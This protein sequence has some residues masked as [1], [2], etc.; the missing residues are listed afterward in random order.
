VFLAKA[1]FIL[2]N[3]GFDTLSNAA[4]CLIRPS[5][6]EPNPTLQQVGDSLC[7]ATVFG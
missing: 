3:L 1:S 4:G 2:F 7:E 5:E 6:A